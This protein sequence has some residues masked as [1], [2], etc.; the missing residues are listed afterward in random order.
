MKMQTP[1]WKLSTVGHA[2]A[3]GLV[4][5]TANA[6]ALKKATPNAANTASPQVAAP[7]APALLGQNHL[8]PAAPMPSSLPPIAGEDIREIRQPRHLSTPW[9]WGLVAAGVFT[10]FMALWAVMR[11][12]RRSR[13]FEMQPHEIALQRLEEARA[14]MDPEQAREYCFS[15]S[16]IIR[17]YIEDEF[18]VQAPRL[19]TEEFLRELVEVRPTLATHRALLGDFLQHCDLAKFAGWRYARPDLEAMHA[20]AVTFVRQTAVAPSPATSRSKHLMLN[21]QTI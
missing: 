17:S 9:R 1:C 11:W 2:L 20:S 19:T 8:T 3:L 12:V 16:T 15:V 14:L 6:F 13:M 10:F 18:Q 5:T 4:L 7:A 21:P